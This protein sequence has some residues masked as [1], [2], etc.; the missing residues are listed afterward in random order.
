MKRRYTL[1]SIRISPVRL[2]QLLFVG[3]EY[4]SP[5]D[6]NSQNW[7]DGCRRSYLEEMISSTVSNVNGK[8]KV[9]FLTL[10]LLFVLVFYRWRR[11]QW[12]RRKRKVQRDWFSRKPID[13]PFFSLSFLLLFLWMVS[14][15][16]Y[17]LLCYRSIVYELALE[18]KG[19]RM[20]TGAQSCATHV[21]K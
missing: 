14:Y 20:K 2:D 19:R 5:I 16:L 15:R 17:K 6:S 18:E 1:D 21:Y 8:Q 4:S 13:G 7:Y 3:R 10:F 12:S 11:P 9:K